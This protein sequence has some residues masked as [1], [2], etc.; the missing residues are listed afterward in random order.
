LSVYRSADVAAYY[1]QLR[2]LSP[3]E[4]LLFERYVKRGD[5]ILDLGVGGGRTTPYLS[6]LASDYVGV[7]YS[8]TMI[9]SCRKKFPAT[10]FVTADAADLSQFGDHSFDI[11]V[12]AF[13]G[14]DYVMPDSKRRQA[15]AEIR[16]VLTPGGMFIFSSH[17]PRSIL[18]RPSW[19]PKRVEN[20]AQRVAREG[21]FWYRIVRWCLTVLR[22]SVAWMEAFALSFMKCLRRLGSRPFWAGTGWMMDSAHGGLITHYA[23]PRCVV[24]ELS[25][26]GFAS[27]E[28]LGDD[29][30]SNSSN[31]W[32]DW[33]YYVF[34]TQMEAG[35]Q[36]CA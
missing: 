24:D 29:H 8:E 26:A 17:N 10:C 21:T 19:N 31:Y 16:R 9:L 7:D 35:A 34:Q 2:Y 32:T 15:L 3:A 28:I 6:E 22:V 12:M 30:P 33:Y 20:V 18:Q 1:E 14:L 27:R 5:R 4:R 11:A 25:S 36:H 23:A 13:N